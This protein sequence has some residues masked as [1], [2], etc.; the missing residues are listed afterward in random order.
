MSDNEK[1]F[2]YLLL[3]A[4]LN[5]ELESDLTNYYWGGIIEAFMACEEQWV[6]PV[7]L[8]PFGWGHGMKRVSVVQIV[9]SHDPCH[10]ISGLI[11]DG[12]IQPFFA[13]DDDD[14]MIIVFKRDEVNVT[15]LANHQYENEYSKRFVQ[16]LELTATHTTS[17]NGIVFIGGRGF[18]A[19]FEIDATEQQLFRQVG[20]RI[21]SRMPVRLK[22]GTR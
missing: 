5:G 11:S 1:V 2:A 21:S 13:K 3:N 17:H 9:L 4:D 22:R 10:W 14:G 8:W 19:D 12:V 20:V 15:A 18:S 16:L 7:G 6:D